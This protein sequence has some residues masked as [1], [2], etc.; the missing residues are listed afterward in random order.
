MGSSVAQDFEEKRIWWIGNN[1]V[2]PSKAKQFE[3]FVIGWNEILKKHKFF[4]PIYYNEATDSTY[5]F[6]LPMSDYATLDRVWADYRKILQ[7][8]GTK[9]H[10]MLASF[11]DAM[12]GQDVRIIETRPDI[13]YIPKE[14]R[15]QPDEELYVYR[16]FLY[17][18]YGTENQVE[19]VFQKAIDLN[20]KH[21]IKDAFRVA[22]A[23]TGTNIPL[24]TV[25]VSARNALDYQEAFTKNVETMG[26]N[27]ESLIAEMRSLER[28]RDVLETTRRLDLSYTPE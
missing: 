5:N 28:S 11:G 24:Y 22:I 3:E 10:E 7:E 18:R 25:S 2:M 21:E 23:I 1:K 19:A 8:E 12:N 15:L 27:Y 16:H 4:A 26:A 17:I 20:K 13:S 14:P 6:A 9:A